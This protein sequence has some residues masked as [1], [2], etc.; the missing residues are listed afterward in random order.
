MTKTKFWM[1]AIL[2][3]GFFVVSCD[4]TDPEPEIN[5]AELLVEYMESATS[6]AANYGNGALAIK[7]AEVVHTSLAAGKSYIVDIRAAAD[8]ANGHIEGAV[9]LVPGDVRGHIDDTDLSA[10]DDII[11]VCY[12]GQTAA[13]LTTL[14]QLA[15]YSNVYSMKFG[16]CA[17]HEDFAGSWNSSIS[18]EKATLFTSDVT[19]KGEAGE[20]PELTT[21]FET[22]EE[23]FDARWDVVLAEGFTPASISVAEVYAALD[24]YYIINYWPEAEYLDPGHIAGAVQY[25][26]GVDL[27][28]GTNLK[29]LPTDKT[30]VVY[31]YTG[32]TS[33]KMAC[34]LRMIGY[35][36][37]SL[38]FGANAMIHDEMTVSPWTTG[39]IMGYDYVSDTTK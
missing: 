26:P 31:C 4:K 12:S 10:Y 2:L 23:I 18:N 1:L 14:L 22:G 11:I 3:L 33:A 37:K 13:W 38:K 21:G 30:V 17:W 9:N 7:S 24:D 5:E 8:Y 39:A 15:G 25:T 34:Y 28:L 16:M 32:Q 6:P 20:L 29:T 35:D 19:A 27:A 36:A